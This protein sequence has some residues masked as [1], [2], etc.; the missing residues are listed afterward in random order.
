MT[1]SAFRGDHA[2][3]PI[4]QGGRTELT[5]DDWEDA[6][7]TIELDPGIF[8]VDARLGWRS[9]PDEPLP[10]LEMSV[11]VKQRRATGG[12]APRHLLDACWI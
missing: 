1:R 10:G 9:S 11:E 12:F 2:P 7:A 4:L 8:S 6:N 5:D 3:D